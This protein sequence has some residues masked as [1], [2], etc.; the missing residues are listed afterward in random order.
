MI[1]KRL[2]EVSTISNPG[3]SGCSTTMS[4]RKILPKACVRVRSAIGCHASVEE[5]DSR[6]GN[7]NTNEDGAKAGQSASDKLRTVGSIG[8]T[9]CEAPIASGRRR[10]RTCSAG[11]REYIQTRTG[12]RVEGRELAGGEE[13]IKG[14]LRPLKESDGAIMPRRPIG[15]C[16]PSARRARRGFWRAKRVL[17]LASGDVGFHQLS[18]HPNVCPASSADTR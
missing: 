14:P 15:I 11:Q 18:A 9:C 2:R 4:A 10:R 6:R 12:R 17:S 3:D 16:R 7:Q 1:A 8:R 5:R 13:G